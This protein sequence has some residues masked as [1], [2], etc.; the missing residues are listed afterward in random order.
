VFNWHPRTEGAA[1][2]MG[3]SAEKRKI[4]RWTRQGLIALSVPVLAALAACDRFS[5]DSPPASVNHAI[6]RP[7]QTEPEPPLVRLL[8][9]QAQPTDTLKEARKL[10]DQGADVNASG[11]HSR[12]PLM[13]ALFE[14]DVTKLLLEHGADPNAKDDRGWT[15]LFF[16]VYNADDEAIRLLLDHGAN[17]NARDE[18]GDTPLMWALEHPRLVKL[19]IERKADVNVKSQDGQSPLSAAL[20][21]KSYEAA[22][23]LREAGAR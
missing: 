16:A 14:P 13:L 9:G 20:A 19:L 5:P 23:L 8:R 10:I 22:R 1:R 3:P 21:L 6:K 12:S 15:P 7:Q 11:D 18:K 2:S 4:V 17:V